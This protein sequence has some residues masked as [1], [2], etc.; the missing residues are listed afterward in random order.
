MP[1]VKCPLLGSCSHTVVQASSFRNQH[2]NKSWTIMQPTKR[3]SRSLPTDIRLEA[4]VCV[5]G[6]AFTD[7]GVPFTNAWPAFQGDYP[8]LVPYARADGRSVPDESLREWCHATISYHH[9]SPAMIE[10]FWHLEQDWISRHNSVSSGVFTAC[11]IHPLID[12]L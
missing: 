12:M 11:T 7:S 4:G 10:E 9:M 8:G 1:G 5:L 6:K 3:K 2:C